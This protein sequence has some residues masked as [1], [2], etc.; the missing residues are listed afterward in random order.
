MAF[1]SREYSSEKDILLT[2]A[3]GGNSKINVAAVIVGK[4][5]TGK[6]NEP[7]NPEVI[8]ISISLN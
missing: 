1:T 4:M 8:I 3:K 7:R 6:Y 2:P 5:V